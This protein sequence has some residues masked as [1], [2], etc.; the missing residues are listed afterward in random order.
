M[1]AACMDQSHLGKD[2]SK[3][4]IIVADSSNAEQLA[5]MARQAKVIINVVGPVTIA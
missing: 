1:H 5:A 3:T 2:L 4:P